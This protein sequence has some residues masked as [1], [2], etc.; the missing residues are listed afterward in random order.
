[1]VVMVGHGLR[2]GRGRGL[3]LGIGGRSRAR[4]GVHDLLA[5]QEEHSQDEILGGAVH[6]FLL[7]GRGDGGV[8][9]LVAER[10]QGIP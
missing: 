10:E 2:R 9:G 7:R 5:R 6:G 1:M 3:L 8:G 4:R